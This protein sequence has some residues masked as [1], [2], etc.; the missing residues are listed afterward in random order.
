MRALR[1]G[2]DQICWSDRGV[3]YSAPAC[4]APAW[5][6]GFYRRIGCVILAVT[7]AHA[8][9]EGRDPSY[10]QGVSFEGRTSGVLLESTISWRPAI[11]GQLPTGVLI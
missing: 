7:S 3:P 1:A 5:C 9:C 6:D 11:L 2:G 10:R 4:T 8:R